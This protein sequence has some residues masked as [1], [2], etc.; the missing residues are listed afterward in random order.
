MASGNNQGDRQQSAR[1]YASSTNDYNGDILAMAR[2]QGV[3]TSL[4][5]NGS[6]LQ[7]INTALNASYTEI[8]GAMAA[9]A[10]SVNSGQANWNELGTF[11]PGGGTDPAAT[12]W[13][14]Q[15]VTNGGTVSAPRLALVS[16]MIAGL[17]TDG[18]WTLLDRLWITAGETTGNASNQQAC[19]DMVAKELASIGANVTW[20]ANGFTNT[21]FLGVGLTSTYNFSTATNWKLNSAHLMVYCNSGYTHVDGPPAWDIASSDNGGNPSCGLNICQTGPA[22]RLSANNTSSNTGVISAGT[23]STIGV[24]SGS[25]AT[26]FYQNGSS[27]Y[28]NTDASNAVPNATLYLGGWSSSGNYLKQYAAFSVGGALTPTQALALYNRV[29]T[30]LSAIGAA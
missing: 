13:A 20:T 23:Q 6:L 18:V 2:Q 3:S 14:A 11:T 21:T 16:A 24:R 29:S 28:T 1:T 5:I 27:T 30:L 8:N 15:V 4:E 26:A 7:Y 19:T 9:Y 12:A 22:G 25:T 10:N 17:K